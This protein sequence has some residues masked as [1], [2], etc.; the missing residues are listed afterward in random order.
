MCDEICEIKAKLQ[1]I[2]AGMDAVLA[3][4]HNRLSQEQDAKP[5]CVNLY[6]LLHVKAELMQRLSCLTQ[7]ILFLVRDPLPTTAPV[8][9]TTWPTHSWKSEPW[10][11]SNSDAPLCQ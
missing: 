5:L 1:V 10:L 6:P 7:Q 8:S 2:D 11:C 9:H 4:I 3:E